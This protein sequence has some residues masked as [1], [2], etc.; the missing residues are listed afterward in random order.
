[1][2]RDTRKDSAALVLG[3]THERAVLVKSLQREINFDISEFKPI[4]TGK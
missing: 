2:P 3:E 1:M 4:F